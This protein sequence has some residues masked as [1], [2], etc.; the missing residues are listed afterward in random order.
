[1][2]FQKIDGLVHKA[3]VLFSA[4]K[5]HTGSDTAFDAVEEAGTGAPFKLFIGALSK[6]KKPGH[7]IEGLP[8]SIGACIGSEVE[9]LFFL[10][11]F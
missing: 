4:A 8:R 10:F 2:T 5:A 6:R 9:G 3:L 11:P 7:E 1:M